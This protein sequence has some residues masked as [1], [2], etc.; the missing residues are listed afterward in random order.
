MKRI[1]EEYLYVPEDGKIKEK[2]FIMRVAVAI[3]CMVCCL[4][5]MGF[6]A[7][8]FFSS[9]IT[10]GSNT[11]MAATYNAE[12]I[13]AE[14]KQ[15]GKGETL[16]EIEPSTQAGD[17]VH[18]FQL[19]SQENSA[20]EY[21]VGI[22]A[23]G[24]AKNGY[25]KIEILGADNEVSDWYYTISIGQEMTLSFT[26]KCYES[27]KVRITANWGSCSETDSAKIIEQNE[28]ITIGNPTSGI[29][30]DTSDDDSQTIPATTPNT[31][32]DSETS[33]VGGD[34]TADSKTETQDSTST[35]G[36]S[37]ETSDS[38]DASRDDSQDDQDSDGETEEKNNEYS[39]EDY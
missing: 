39:Q 36:E 5:A 34:T 26:I 17:M 8:A 13:V 2:V 1:Y 11:I 25:C 20:K 12:I 29:L 18:T 22:T 21:T 10:S 33:S 38:S 3:V 19:D 9:S 14:N 35:S 31:V 16:E 30:D 15:D 32:S 4:S 23:T 37:T 24:N 27:A 6:S 7:Y 28:K